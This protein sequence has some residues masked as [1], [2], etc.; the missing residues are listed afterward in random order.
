MGLRIFLQLRQL[1]LVGYVTLGGNQNHRLGLKTSSKVLEFI[2]DDFKIFHRIRAPARIRHIHQM[3][4]QS[5]ALYVA[6]E[7]Y[8][9]ARALMRALDQAGNICD[10]ETSALQRIAYDDHYAGTADYPAE[11]ERLAALM[12]EKPIVF[13]KNHGILVTGETV[14]QAY[15]RL[16]KLERV[17]RTQILALSTGKPLEVL[18]DEV[19]AAVQ[20]PGEL[21]S[22]SREERDRLFF[23]A[24]MRMLDRVMPGYAS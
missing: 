4:Q 12:G 8:A 14:A 7:L 24:M 19:V 16:Y 10:H 2:H 20:A 6:E 18:S 13:M 9:Q 1:A 22:H 3:H 21:E 17:C 11:G 15:R 23:E 5:R